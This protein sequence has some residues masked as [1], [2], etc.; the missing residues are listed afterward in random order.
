MGKPK[1]DRRITLL[2][3][4][5]TLN[6]FGEVDL[7]APDELGQIWASFTPVSDAERWRAGQIEAVSMARFVLR[8]SAIAASLSAADRL[9]LDGKVWQISGRKELGRRRW[10]ELTATQSDATGE[11]Q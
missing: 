8:W 1:L 3:A 4:R 2:R 5:T 10:I 7:S 6:D 11:V 9:K